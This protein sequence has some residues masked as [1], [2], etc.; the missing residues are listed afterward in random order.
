MVFFLNNFNISILKS[1][2][3][4]NFNAFMVR[5]HFQNSTTLQANTSMNI[6]KGKTNDY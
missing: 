6:F 4:I 3:N 5:T 1:I 2:K